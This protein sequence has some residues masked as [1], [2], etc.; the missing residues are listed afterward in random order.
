MVKPTL[1][2][3]ILTLKYSIFEEIEIV[4][5]LYLTALFV[6]A[7]L[8]SYKLAISVLYYNIFSKSEIDCT[9]NLL[10]WTLE[11]RTPT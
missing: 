10:M 2:L 5:K 8:E 6:S 11:M 9:V 7:L 4:I 3:N 1:K